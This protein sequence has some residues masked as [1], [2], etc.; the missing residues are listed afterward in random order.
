MQLNATARR[1]WFGALMLVCALGLLVAGETILKRRL[2]GLGFLLYWGLCFVFTGLAILTAYIDARV[3][4]IKSRKETRELLQTTLNKI[5]ND[6]RN[7]PP[8]DRNI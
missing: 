1:R 2:E 6:A 4:Q 8:S 5:Q 3:L 7:K